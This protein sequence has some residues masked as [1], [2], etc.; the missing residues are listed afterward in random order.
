V[1]SGKD[2]S[3]RSHQ[4]VTGAELAAYHQKPAS[5]A[6]LLD[7]LG[8]KIFSLP[9]VDGGAI[10][11]LNEAGDALVTAHLKLSDDFTGIQKGYKG[12]QYFLDRRDVNVR[13]FQSGKVEIVSDDDLDKFAETTRMRFKRW[14][15]RNLIVVPL[16]AKQSD[17][18][19]EII[20]TVSVFGQHRPLDPELAPQIDAI[21]NL[22]SMHLQTQWNHHQAIERRKIAGAMSANIQEFF[23]CVSEINSLAS[24]ES[25][26]ASIATEFLQHFRF[27]MINVLLAENGELEIVHAGFSKAFQHLAP[28]MSQWASNT[29]YSFDVS[30]GQCGFVFTHN[31]HFLLDDVMKIRHLPMSDKDRMFVDVLGTVRTLLIV[32]IRLNKSVIGTITLATLGETVYPSETDLTLIELLA[33]FIST[34]IRNAKTHRMVQQESSKIGMM[35]Q[36]LKQQMAL[37]NQVASKDRLTGLNNFGNFEE[38]LKRRTSEYARAGSENVLSVILVDVDYFKQFN[39][40]YG[41]LAGNL[42]LQEVGARISN[43]AR[44]MDF[45]ARYGGEEFIMLL[46]QCDLAGAT[47]IAERIRSR[48]AETPFV[49]DG[50]NHTINISGGCA[51]FSP[52]ES[53]RDFIYRVDAAL[54]CAKRNG[55]NCIEAASSAMPDMDQS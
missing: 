33:S 44:D 21:A 22:S 42:V 48:I 13:V 30:D 38:E 34:A 20:G 25:V 27:D 49:V 43:C 12:F 3:G 16:T 52:V 35:N 23:A 39:D 28:A 26:Y 5:L 9:D 17:G 19:V 18:T 11:L 2:G 41:H 15:M 37:L 46:P 14:Q 7:T 45:V 36:D 31:Q 47:A 29:R 50:R 4:D 55:R 24:V 10:N 54:Y 1:D 8:Q 40:A 53:A 32:P 51:Q 6:E